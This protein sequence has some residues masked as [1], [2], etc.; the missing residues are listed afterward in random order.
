MAD[1][2]TLNI[3]GATL[4][5][6]TEVAVTRGIERMPSSFDIT[7]TEKFPGEAASLVA[8]PGDTCVVNI[9]G[10]PVITGYVD[11]LIPSIDARGHSV[12]VVGRSKS[13]DL[14]DCSAEWPGGQIV[15]SSAL[16]IATKLAKPYG[17]TVKGEVDTGAPIPQFNLT[18][19]ESAYAIIERVCRYR[20]LLV[21]D[22]PDGSVV[23][24]QAGG[25][26]LDSGIKEGS[27]IQIAEGI[28][29]MDE[30]FSDYDCFLQAMDVLADTGE[31]G[32]LIFHAT[33][34]GVKRH[35]QRDIIAEAGGGGLDVCKQRGQW[36]CNRRAGRAN[37]ITATVDSWR[38]GGGKLWEPN[39]LIPV[40]APFLKAPNYN[41]LLG[42][43]TFRLGER[44][45]SADMLIMPK[46]AFLPEP[47]LLQPFPADVPPQ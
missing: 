6:W 23:L 21:Y 36:E 26:K 30:R 45:T 37:I 19:G 3:G 16:Q 39:K 31:G 35:R 4:G 44:G 12:R 5:G 10:E 38:T 7:M 41:W 24:N 43:V 8:Q 25:G 47:I 40:E 9:G 11:R 29:S 14:V 28:Y 18:L 46:E 2:V 32:N 22:M 33:D 34:K 42:E 1:D 15:G 20:G 17:I 13:Q 27:N